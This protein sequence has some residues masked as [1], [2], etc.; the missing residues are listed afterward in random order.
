M[1]FERRLRFF[2]SVPTRP[3]QT[4]TDFVE[5]KVQDPVITRMR[6]A[7]L[8]QLLHRDVE[9]PTALQRAVVHGF[10]TRLGY[11]W[12]AMQDPSFDLLTPPSTLLSDVR[13]GLVFDF[14]DQTFN[15]SCPDAKREPATY[16][17]VENVFGLLDGLERGLI[18]CE[19]SQLLDR[20]NCKVCENGSVVVKLNDF[21]YNEVR[22]W[23]MKLSL[24]DEVLTRNLL[25]KLNGHDA[26][27]CER[28]IS[29]LRYP[30]ICTDQSPD[31]VRVESAA[32][33]R[34]KMW[35]SRRKR[36]RAE[37]QRPSRHPE[38]Q[39]IRNI[40]LRQVMPIPDDLKAM[41]V[42]VVRRDAPLTTL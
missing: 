25:Q 36:I 32:D 16:A 9:P 4:Q 10:N 5:D 21:R 2:L 3:A 12:L 33:F 38:T 41:C 13:P 1:S 30:V 40:Q 35:T 28:E 19:L 11:L 18:T 15:V 34:K 29:I 22:T 7:D 37:L 31:V 23:C 6:E 20:F 39:A 27:Q 14:Y 8:E 24:S 42:N 17:Y 26:I